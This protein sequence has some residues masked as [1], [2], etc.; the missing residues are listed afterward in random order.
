[1]NVYSAK[2]NSAKIAT[3]GSTNAKFVLLKKSFLNQLIYASLFRYLEPERESIT[4]PTAVTIQTIGSTEPIALNA[5]E[6]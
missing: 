2:E 5:L 3:A 4:R 1:M 6:L